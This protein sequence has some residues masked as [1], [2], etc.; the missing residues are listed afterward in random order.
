MANIPKIDGFKIPEWWECSWRRIGC[1]KKTCRLCGKI[2]K[3]RQG[4]ISKGEDP[5]SLESALEDVGGSFREAM[6]MIKKHAESMGID[7]TNIDSIKEPPEPN[8]LPLYRK[9]F[10]W[11]NFIN[12]IIKDAYQ[13]ESL[14]LATEAA[15]DLNWYKDTLSAKTYRQLCNKW[16]IEQGDEY[17]DF[18]HKYTKYIL[19][20]CL[21]ILECALNDLVLLN[22]PQ[23][24]SLTMALSQFL[25]IEKKILSI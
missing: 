6:S 8:K 11:R 23:K 5:D 17:G 9:I 7:I 4:H 24:V 21:R 19:D 25:E 15:A 20:E 10:K 14:W 12:D 3:D 1:G 22:S 16:H 13:T 18:D 2:Q